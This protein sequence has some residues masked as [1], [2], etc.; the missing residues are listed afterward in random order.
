MRVLVTGGA[1]FIGS[2]FIRFLL[3][4]HPSYQVVNL[5]K[6][7][8]AG[9]LERLRDVASNPRYEFV[10]GDICDSALVGHLMRE[11][12]AVA[13]FAAETHVDRALMDPGAF[14][15]TDVYGTYVLL[16]AAH[17]AGVKRFLHV[18]T[19]EVYG[20]V[21]PGR[22][23]RE[24]DP[25]APRNPYSASKAGA[26]MQVSAFH[27]TYGLP[28]VI[29]RPANNVGPY[30]HPE[31]VVPLFVTNAL[32][33]LPLPVYGDGRQVRDWLYVEDNCEALDLLLHQGT[34]GQ[35]YNIPAGNLREN[36]Y[37]TRLLLKLLGKPESLLR[38][39][40]DRP[41]HD[42]R[43][44]MDGTKLRT[45]GWAPR[46]SFEQALEKTVAWYLDNRWWWERIIQ[47]SQFQDYYRAQYE[48]RLRPGQAPPPS[49]S[50][51][52]AERA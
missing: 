52:R 2:N 48:R 11:V 20:E 25:P 3:E 36:V 9:N 24:D 45:L 31:K 33:D 14:I 28:V 17:E 39:V 51:H 23:S 1:G 34:T 30:Q 18:S 19:D 12:D 43:Y 46:H 6:L 50:V 13:H 47:T 7:T 5:D 32:Q 4:R 8:Y 49:N 38:F 15:T 40:E 29:A 27:Q 22:S 42:R 10:Q 44:C 37:M 16:R 41:G 26:E 35:A 21:P